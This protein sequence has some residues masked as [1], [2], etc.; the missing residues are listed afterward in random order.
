MNA[1][2]TMRNSP[3][4]LNLKKIFMKVR[5]QNIARVGVSVHVKDGSLS[6]EAAKARVEAFSSKTKPRF[7]AALSILPPHEADE[8]V[9]VLVGNTKRAGA[10]VRGK[11]FAVSPGNL[12]TA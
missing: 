10:T 9:G 7:F 11:G 12:K 2:L 8:T 3:E 4:I 6:I 1:S 5:K